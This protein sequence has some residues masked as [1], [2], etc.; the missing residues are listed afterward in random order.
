[1]AEG[2]VKNCADCLHNAVCSIWRENECQD[3][4]LYHENGECFYGW[5][6]V[7][8][9]MP[10]EYD[11]VFKHLKGTTKWKKGMFETNSDAVLVSVKYEDGTRE[12]LPSYTVD[13]KW[14]N[15]SAIRKSEVTHWMPMPKPKEE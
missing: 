11:S 14:G 15:L 6:S 8:D 9:D 12:T 10:P 2:K 5:I 3:A 4:S 13:G 1:M 7:K